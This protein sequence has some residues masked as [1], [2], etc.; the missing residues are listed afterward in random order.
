M[1]YKTQGERSNL[2]T[3]KMKKKKID[4]MNMICKACE[5]NEAQE[6]QSFAQGHWISF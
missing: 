5:Y 3:F 2:N 1:T 6:L 4:H